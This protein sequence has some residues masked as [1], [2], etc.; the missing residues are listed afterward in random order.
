MFATC[1]TIVIPV[2]NEVCSVVTQRQF[3]D[4][5]D[6]GRLGEQ[7][8]KVW[9]KVVPGSSQRAT[10]RTPVVAHYSNMN[11]LANWF[12]VL[13]APAFGNTWRDFVA[14]QNKWTYHAQ[15]VG[16]LKK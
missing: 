12:C 11:A 8:L 15:C 10:L 2:T 9:V 4:V 14:V 16:V 1:L 6:G 7:G 5:F 3:N 13:A